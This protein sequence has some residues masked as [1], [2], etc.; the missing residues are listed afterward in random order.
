MEVYCAG[1]L[2]SFDSWIAD[3]LVHIVDGYV[4][5]M[6]QQHTNPCF[7]WLV[8]R[9]KPSN[10]VCIDD[11]PLASTIL[12]SARSTLGSRRRN[13]ITCDVL[14]SV[15]SSSCPPQVSLQ[16]PPLRHHLPLAAFTFSFSVHYHRTLFVLQSLPL[17]ASPCLRL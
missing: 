15:L 6:L 2:N 17:W 9:L 4:E 1:S 14:N 8:I 5:V 12:L 3:G 16:L 13:A 11:V 7:P 10:S